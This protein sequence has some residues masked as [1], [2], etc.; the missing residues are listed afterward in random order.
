MNLVKVLY[1]EYN[2]IDIIDIIKISIGKVYKVLYSE[3]NIIDIM[4]ISIDKV[5]KRFSKNSSTE[6]STR[7]W[8]Y[9]EYNTLTIIIY[10]LLRIM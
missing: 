6:M 10:M 4:K 8:L 1:S 3:Y 7:I 9:S 5:Y 2:I